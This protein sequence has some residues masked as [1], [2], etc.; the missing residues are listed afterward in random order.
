MALE[1]RARSRLIRKGRI[2]LEWLQGGAEIALDAFQRRLVVRFEADHDHGRGVRSTGKAEAVLVFDSHAVNRK[3]AL[4]AWEGLRRLQLRDERMRLA[5][6]QLPVDLG[7]RWRVRQALQHGARIPLPREHLE[8]ARAAVEG[9]VE[10]VPAFLEEGVAGHLAGEQRAGLL[11]LRLDE[12]V[13][14][15]PDERLAA[16][17]LDPGRK[18]ARAL[19]VVDDL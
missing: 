13:A 14:G 2:G 12:R 3:H 11:Q 8:Q 18:Q 15:L 17:A 9:I 1:L 16:M 19:H 7:S 4:G 6:F 5:F 10:A